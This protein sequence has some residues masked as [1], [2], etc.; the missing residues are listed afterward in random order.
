MSKQVQSHSTSLF[1]PK[2]C[3]KSLLDPDVHHQRRPS[4][5][6]HPQNSGICSSWEITRFTEEKMCVYIYI[7]IHSCEKYINIYEHMRYHVELKSQFCKMRSTQEKNEMI[8][9]VPSLLNTITVPYIKK[10]TCITT[11]SFKNPRC[12]K[13]FISWWRINHDL[14][15]S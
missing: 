1:S 3:F 4:A 11:G 6:P 2:R 7:H 13:T 5:I 12:P 15:P 14:L 10:N 8:K 9:V